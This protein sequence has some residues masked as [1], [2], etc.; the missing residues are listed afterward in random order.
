MFISAGTMLGRYRIERPI[1][2]GGMGEVY[3]A[4]D[5]QLGRV[6]ALKVLPEDRAGDE[7]RLHRFVRE[8]QLASALNHPAIVTVYDAGE[9][10]IDAGRSVRFL[11]MEL[12]EGQNLA[13]W[14]HAQRDRRKIVASLAEIADGLASAHA[15]GI[16]HRDLKPANIVVSESGHPKI[17]DFGIAKLTER[18]GDE[19]FTQ[20]DTAPAEAIGTPTYMSPEQIDR[21]KIDARSDI[22]S[23]GCVMIEVL[24]G[25]PPFRRANAVESMHAVL[26]DELPPLEALPADLQR[27]VRK[28][29]RK[30]REERYQSARDIALDLRDSLREPQEERRKRRAVAPIAITFAVA[31]IIM[32][33]AWWLLRIQRPASV[34][35]PAAKPAQSVMERLTNSGNVPEG[36]ISPDGKYLVY[37]TI[38][39]R[40][41]TLWV[42][43]VATLANVQVIPPEPVNYYQLQVSPDGDYVYYYVARNSNSVFADIM[44]MPLLGG[45]RRRI[46]ENV[47]GNFSLSPDGRRIAF[48]RFN[49]VERVYR[50]SVAQVENGTETELTTRRFPEFIGDLTWMPDGK[51]IAFEQWTR[52]QTK[53]SQ[54]LK[55]IDIASRRTMAIP[56]PEWSGFGP[57]AAVPD[58]SGLVLGAFDGK[59][60][61]QIWFLATNGQATKITSD[62]GSYGA[63]T[64]DHFS[65]FSV[66][67]DSRTLVANREEI[68]SNVWVTGR[69]GHDAHSVTHGLGNFIDTVRWMPN[70]RIL[71]VGFTPEPTPYTVEENGDDARRFSRDL[72]LSQ[73]A[74]APDGRRIAFVRGSLRGGDL[75]TAD[76]NG[77]DPKLIAGLGSARRP[78]WSGDGR[79]I[80]FATMGRVQAIWSIGA[81]GGEPVRITNRPA[82]DPVP[83]P[84]GLWLLCSL[85][86]A[87]PHPSR[88][89]QIALLRADGSGEPRYFPVPNSKVTMRWF[90]DSRRFAFADGDV[91]AQNIWAQDLAGG[92]PRQL[93]HFDSGAIESFDISRDGRRLAITRTFRV[94]DEVLIRNFR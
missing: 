30:D 57:I 35:A 31:A 20:T 27:I 15:G 33:M 6:V 24:L 18:S 19:V 37:A 88:L 13:T 93:T 79:T 54:R 9:A 90:P 39:G 92:A 2:A 40:N 86:S 12:I 72:V 44:R 63:Y 46:V 4:T 80:F 59:Q 38:D 62:L 22:F 78:E 16:V 43:Q 50:L 73:I 28:C 8:A 41:Q 32:G 76:I 68:S 47:D 26:H 61:R 5:T 77:E 91:R 45:E 65:S 56:S 75:W 64:N 67:K 36:A 84:D 17:L 85:R 7:G 49:A 55:T 42:R 34:M 66:T 83:S 58:G 94:S 3:A 74:I 10:S 89:W 71:Y 23:F 21:A 52:G 48:I 29:L 60:F 69:D 87:D 1:G 81:D 14:S 51:R 25:A 82:G 53:L 70:G 11:T